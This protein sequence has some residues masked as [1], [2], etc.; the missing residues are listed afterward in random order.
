MSIFA[1]ITILAVNAVIISV[2]F[3]FAFGIESPEYAFAVKGVM[4]ALAGF[5]F[6][7]FLPRN[8]IDKRIG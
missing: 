2:Q 1:L 7:L 4:Y 6:V 8:M 5:M 3:M